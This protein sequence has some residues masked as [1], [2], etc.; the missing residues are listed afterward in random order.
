VAEAAIEVKDLVKI[1][2]DA[3]VT[4]INSLKIIRGQMVGILGLNGRGNQR[5][6]I[7]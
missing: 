3:R 7:L 1:F 5:R 6:S 2:G 4:D